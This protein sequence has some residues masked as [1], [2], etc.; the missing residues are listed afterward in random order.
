MLLRVWPS[1]IWLRLPMMSWR[2]SVQAGDLEKTWTWKELMDFK[3]YKKKA[4]RQKALEVSAEME[5]FQEI[6]PTRW[7]CVPRVWSTAPRNWR[8][9]RSKWRWSAYRLSWLDL[10]YSAWCVPEFSAFLF[11]DLSIE[12]LVSSL[13]WKC[14]RRSFQASL[15]IATLIIRST[16]S[17]SNSDDCGW[18]RWKDSGPS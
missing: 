17:A 10:L 18:K 1:V 3:N 8:V 11:Q 5:E 13:R 9:A 2:T 16:C 7:R 14:P 6:P 4:G 12:I 15:S